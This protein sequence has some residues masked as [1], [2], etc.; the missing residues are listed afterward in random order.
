LTG[1]PIMELK[2]R[3]LAYGAYTPICNATGLPAMSVPL[4]WNGA[5]LPIGVQFMGRFADESTLFAL[6]GQLER[7]RPWFARRPP[8]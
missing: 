4:H 3:V 2:D 1:L 7:T 6:A 5:G 8:L